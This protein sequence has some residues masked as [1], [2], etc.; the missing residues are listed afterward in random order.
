MMPTSHNARM[1][2]LC[3]AFLAQCD[4]AGGGSGAAPDV[5][6]DT[7]ADAAPVNEC[8]DD[9]RPWPGTQHCA[10]RVDEC[11]AWELPVVGGGCLPIGP[12]GCPK[13]WA[14]D[15]TA[16][17]AP[18]D[19]VPCPEGFILTDDEAAC[20]PRFDADC[21]EAEI[22]VLGGGCRKI[23]PQWAAP[24]EIFFDECGADELSLPGG[25]CV[26]AGP[27]A[28]PELWEHGAGTGCAVGDVLPCPEGWVEGGGGLYCE[29][30]YADC[31]AGSVPV[32]GGA[33][34]QM[35]SD[36]DCPDAPY[37]AP[38]DE[39]GDVFYVNATSGCVD[40]CGSLEAPFPSIQAAVDAAPTGGWVLVGPG[41]YA[42]GLS[43]DKPVHV[44]GL[45][46]AEVTLTG[47][48]LV[49]SSE[50]TKVLEAGISVV[51]S[52]K[53]HVSG[54]RLA[55][56]AAGIAVVNASADLDHLEIDGVKGVGIYVDA[57]STVEIVDTWIH[58]VAFG[59]GLLG[60]GSGL[61][62]HGG[63]DVM[64][65]S[66]LIDTA[67]WSGMAA[68]GA[69]T[70]LMA[71]DTVVRSTRSDFNGNGGYGLEMNAAAKATLQR[72]LLE[73]NRAASL[74]VR[75]TSRL[76]M[77]AC[78][79]RHTQPLESD[80]GIGGHGADVFGGSQIL[81]SRSVIEDSSGAGIQIYNPGTK[82]I[83]TASVIRDTA[84]TV[85]DAAGMGMG[86]FYGA[87]A[88]VLGSAVEGNTR[89]GIFAGDEG[90][91]LT[92]A[93][94]TI[95]D[96][97]AGGSSNYGHGISV[98]GGADASV[99]RSVFTRNTLVG[100]TVANPSSH[101]EVLESVVRDTEQDPFGSGGWAINSYD[102]A[103]STIID[104]LIEGATGIGVV[105][106]DSGTVVEVEG[107]VIRATRQLPG[108]AP[109]QGV[110]VSTGAAMTLDMC[111][112][113]GNMGANVLAFEPG[114][115]MSVVDTIVRDSFAGVDG[116]GGWGLYVAKDAN[117][118][119]TGALFEGNQ[120]LGIGIFGEGNQLVVA[121]SVV[122][123]TKPNPEGAEGRGIQIEGGINAQITSSVIAG[124]RGVGL[125]IMEPGAEVFVGDSVIRDTTADDL[126]SGGV[127]CQ[128][129]NGAQVEMS[130]SQVQ[131]SHELGVLIDGPATEVHIL[132]CVVED[133]AA[134]TDGIH[135]AG[136]SAQNRAT[137]SVQGSLVRESAD[138]GIGNPQGGVLDVRGTLVRN[139]TQGEGEDSRPGLVVDGGADCEVTFSLFERN[140]TAG[141][142]LFGA[143]SSVVVSS[144]A[145]LDTAG[146]TAE[147][148]QPDGSTVDVTFGDG[149]MAKNAE[150]AVTDTIIAGNGRSGVYFNK[151]SGYITG[152]VIIGNSS[153]GLVM[154]ESR[155]DLVFEKTGNYILGNAL[156]MPAGRARDITDNPGAIPV[157]PA[158]ELTD[159][160]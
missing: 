144:C 52:E 5:F 36:E 120:G 14:A 51:D 104:C 16:A 64:V 33:C 102:L 94:S 82:A 76:T 29:P 99:I 97:H 81:I 63:S 28:C 27:R 126:G 84:P 123:D 17:C 65:Q 53:V 135:G 80:E 101:L 6:A 132:G 32:L 61:I 139:G 159:I 60:K 90:T 39:A 62:V 143:G 148:F 118:T 31:P 54:L 122:R 77:E 119:V 56:W 23:G 129:G 12:R 72:V 70:Q 45:C 1:G 136:I 42:E 151:A 46:A 128:F 49:L 158:V 112:V 96:N 30:S 105:A 152:S 121:D 115:Q 146:G 113:E 25:G 83:V 154:S 58:D 71:S 43:I 133:T 110:L 79:V 40:D 107:S 68:D 67:R 87:E 142:L 2:L 7:E 19:L 95:R 26:L 100:L 88:T 59:S 8:P 103:A 55:P 92:V 18:G 116:L 85:S 117:A 20:V 37:P 111:L 141:L 131:G 138:F 9:L 15:A 41:S 75:D 134:N 48:T 11:E 145:I 3:L 66:S 137:A 73:H 44:V 109:A 4:G 50:G 35:V 149:I 127:G 150:V 21:L 10:P 13:T 34:A 106:Y 153:F 130:R 74:I 91:T 93:G 114:S 108:A 38:P 57:A 69:G 124:N 125:T 78:A 155:G 47:K 86:V 147:L 89:Y 157:P 24:G 140:V 156:D 22:P 98:F 160:Y